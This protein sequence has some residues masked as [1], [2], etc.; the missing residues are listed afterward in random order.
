MA[1]TPDELAAVTR[2]L[3]VDDH[4]LMVE[5]LR[6]LLSDQ[7]DF[8][9][10]GTVGTGE[11]ARGLI[12]ELQPDV[13]VVDYTLPDADGATVA[14]QLLELMPA[15]KAIMLTGS[16][17]RRALQAAF[18]AGCVGFL[19][20][21]SAADRLPAAI[22]AAAAGETFFSPA[23]LA[24]LSEWRHAT[25]GQLSDR[26]LEILELMAEGMS[27]KAIAEQLFVTVNTVRTHTQTIL[28]KLGAHSKL[29]A[30]SVARRHGL[31]D[32]RGT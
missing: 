15:A 9:V 3:L 18:R 27:N 16:D 17:D 13:V 30:V 21:T 26:E 2:I 11:A 8:D 23:D 20:K 4:D 24:R 5:A 19:E 22:R 1:G 29:E 28:E 10:V 7:P 14:A 12:K 6:R 32:R 25:P 31:L